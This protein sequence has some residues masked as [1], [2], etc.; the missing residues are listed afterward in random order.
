[1]MSPAGYYNRLY[2]TAEAGI[3]LHKV[4]KMLNIPHASA[5]F[6]TDELTGTMSFITS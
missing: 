4:C 1:M 6:T 5:G 3:L 2:Y